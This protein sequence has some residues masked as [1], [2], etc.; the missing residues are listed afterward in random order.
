VLSVGD[1]E[2]GVVDLHIFN[3]A[4]VGGSTDPSGTYVPEFVRKSVPHSI[5]GRSEGWFFPGEYEA[6]HPTDVPVASGPPD[7]RQ[8]GVTLICT[9]T[10]WD[11]PP[12]SYAFQWRR[13][14]APVGE[15]RDRYDTVTA[16]IGASLDCV[17]TATNSV[18]STSVTSNAVIVEA[19]PGSRVGEH[20]THVPA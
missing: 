13:D 16:D 18:G 12:T 5:D 15:N 10:N 20:D 4:M 1:A 8:E 2:A 3:G 11:A 7:V 9:T 17:L 19:P 14:G 6:Q